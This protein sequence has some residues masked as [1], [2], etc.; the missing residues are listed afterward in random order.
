MINTSS[1]EQDQDQNK[2]QD[3]NKDIFESWWK[4]YDLKIGKPKTIE[5]WKKKVT[6]DLYNDIMQHTMEYVKG[7]KKYRKHPERYIRDKKWEDEIVI[8]K[9][10]I[11]LKDFRL[12]STGY[13][14][15]GYCDKCNVSG[16]YKKEQLNGDSSCC[17]AK[18]K[19]TK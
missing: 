15:I 7:D 10:Q 17:S 19:P 8:V 9:E 12:D 6:P 4:I 16:F 18:I 13:N 3:I 1:T 14:Y 11:S 2:V 5:Q